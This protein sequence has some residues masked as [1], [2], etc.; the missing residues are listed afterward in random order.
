M[1][2]GTVP[3][4]GVTVNVAVAPYRFR[5]QDLINPKLDLSNLTGFENLSGLVSGFIKSAFL[6]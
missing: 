6:N 3:L 4:V 1:V 2:K 5:I